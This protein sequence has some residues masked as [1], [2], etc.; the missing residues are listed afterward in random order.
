[1]CING[2]GNLS[3]G[4]RVSYIPNIYEDN[5]SLLQLIGKIGILTEIT[6]TKNNQDQLYKIKYPIG[7]VKGI[8]VFCRHIKSE[9]D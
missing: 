7:S 1:M 4:D 8:N 6:K 9:E 2:N 3:I 5:K